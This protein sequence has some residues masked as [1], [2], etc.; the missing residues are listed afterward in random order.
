M[1]TMAYILGSFF[2]ISFLKWF[3]V[4]DGFKGNDITEG[5]F[6]QTSWIGSSS[7]AWF[8]F[9]AFMPIVSPGYAGDAKWYP[10]I[11]AGC[12]NPTN[13][14]KTVTFSLSKGSTS[15][16]ATCSPIEAIR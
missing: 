9:M 13:P 11:C 3:N 1:K 12:N 7:F 16:S 10:Q 4:H 6:A 5:I 8:S 2:I 15:C 14:L